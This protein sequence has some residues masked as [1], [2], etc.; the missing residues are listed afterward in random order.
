MKIPG[1]KRHFSAI[2]RIGSLF[3]RNTLVSHRVASLNANECASVTTLRLGEK[4]DSSA[5]S[6]VYAR[7]L[8]SSQLGSPA[9]LATQ[10]R[11]SANGSTK[12]TGSTD[13]RSKSM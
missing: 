2:H 8:S 12:R 3:E 13:A 5:L 9:V 4:R 10:A 11:P 7:R 1:L 6:S